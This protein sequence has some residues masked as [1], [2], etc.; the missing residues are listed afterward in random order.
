MMETIFRFFIRVILKIPGN[1][2]IG[3]VR[4]V[5]YNEVIS[6]R[7]IEYALIFR[8]LGYLKINNT[9]KIL[10]IG[11]FYSN[12]P[13]QLASMG[14]KVYGLDLMNYSLLHPNFTFVKGDMVNVKFP[15]KSFDVV[16]A[17]STIEHIGMGIYGDQKN[18]LADH[19]AVEKIFK[20]IRKNGLFIFTVPANI[21][22]RIGTSQRFYDLDS[23]NKLLNERFLI[24]K[25]V[26]F[27]EKN[28]KWI[29]TEIKEIPNYNGE[30][31]KSML[32]VVCKK[33]IRK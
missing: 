32:M 7:I 24:K 18:L 29:P 14:Y 27:K 23:I 13:I 11:C 1:H 33:L 8:E 16:T 6:E 25:I 26:A 4:N 2:L 5:F 20:L 31:T 21:R 15:D 17:I 10:D 12:F 3:A 19:I 30:K 22:F 9:S 28:D